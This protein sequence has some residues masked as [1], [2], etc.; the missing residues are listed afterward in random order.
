M[1]VS[2]SCSVPIVLVASDAPIAREPEPA[3]PDAKE[4]ATAAT[5][6]SIVGVL[7]A[8][9][10]TPPPLVTAL[11]WMKAL[12]LPVIAFLAEAPPPLSERFSCPPTETEIDAETQ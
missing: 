6:A 8:V 12:V 1:V 4:I 7:V 10:V 2:S 3:P 11:S 9:S 5:V